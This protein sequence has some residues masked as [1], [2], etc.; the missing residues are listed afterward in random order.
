MHI[1]EGYGV[2][3]ACTV[4]NDTKLRNDQIITRGKCKNQLSSRLFNASPYLFRGELEPDTESRIRQGEFNNKNKTCDLLSEKSLDV[5]T[6]MLPCL[7]ENIQDDKHIIPTWARGGEHTRDHIKQ[8]GFLERN[9]YVKK[10]NV[11]LK[12][13]CN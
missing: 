3:N 2:A 6:P 10:N 4:D 13:N 9:G 5:F 12:K 7:K 11:W 1:K 8:Q